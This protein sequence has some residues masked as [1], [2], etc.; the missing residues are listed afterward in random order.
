LKDQE[1]GR[2][3]VENITWYDACEFCNRLS[4]AEELPAYY[5][6]VAV[7]KQGRHITAADVKP[8]GGTGYRLPTEAEFE[9][10][11]RAGTATP[12][13]FGSIHD[14]TQ[15][16]VMGTRPYGTTKPGVFLNRTTKVGSYEPNA[17]GIY[18]VDGNV[19]EWCWDYFDPRYYARFRS[20]AAVDPVGPATGNQRCNRS[21]SSQ[22]EPVYGRSG[23][24]H[25]ED[26]A[27]RTG[28]TGLRVVRTAE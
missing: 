8:L 19:A 11:A 6:M 17:L 1:I 28:W 22:Y 12:Y 2:F 25:G 13:P 16:N 15:G 18:D 23:R 21:N 4:K 24:R 5:E 20:A 3:P 14:G 26:P 27:L 7:E 10:F 9:W